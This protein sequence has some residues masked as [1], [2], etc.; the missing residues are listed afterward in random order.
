V[1]ISPASSS[2]RGRS[3][4]WICTVLGLFENWDCTVGERQLLQGDTLVLY[5]DGVTESLNDD[6]DEFSEQRLLNAILLNHNLPPEEMVRA[7]LA[8]VQDFGG[9]EQHDDI[10]LIVARV[11]PEPA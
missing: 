9:A 2:R 7:I 5:T 6:G 4:G 1:A 11:P 3:S 10:T 8:A